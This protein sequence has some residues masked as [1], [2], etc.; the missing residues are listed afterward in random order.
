MRAN[1]QDY[2]Q[3]DETQ[4][5]FRQID[6]INRAV[7]GDL[8]SLTT[9]NGPDATMDPS[10]WSHR[11]LYGVEFLG[12]MLE[13][14]LDEERKEEISDEID[15]FTEKSD[16]ERG[17][18]WGRVRAARIKFKNYIRVLQEHNMAFHESDSFVIDNPDSDEAESEGPQLE[19][20]GSEVTEEVVE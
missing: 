19:T 13:P 20:E 15:E 2:K 12:S 11:I 10:T 17:N 3:L 7:T 9:G 4:L 1:S 8:D 6:R 14:I 18:P 5:I 16:Y